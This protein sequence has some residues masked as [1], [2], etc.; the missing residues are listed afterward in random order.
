MDTGFRRRCSFL[1]GPYRDRRAI[2]PLDVPLELATLPVEDLDRRPGAESQ[3]AV[4]L[5]RLFWRQ[6]HGLPRT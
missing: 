4:Q 2:D 1:E 5:T 3:D 6:R